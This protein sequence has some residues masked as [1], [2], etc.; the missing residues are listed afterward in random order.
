MN[1]D[2]FD[3][4][5]YFTNINNDTN[6]N[7]M[8]NNMNNNIINQNNNSSLFSPYEGYLR[9]NLFKNLYNGYKNYKP[10][11]INISND[12]DEMLL[13]I[14]QLSFAR[15]ELNLLLDNYPNNINALNLFNRYREMELDEVKKYERKFGPLTITSSDINKKPFSWVNDMWPWEV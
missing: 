9:G 8:N 14:G 6:S 15:H 3:E 5:D 2:M 11:N 4:I 7:N 1:Y 13:N 10:A 12:R